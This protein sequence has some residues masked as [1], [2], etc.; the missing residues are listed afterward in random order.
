MKK[1]V[2]LG[3]AALC[4]TTAALAGVG[5]KGKKKSCCKKET[6]SCCKKTSASCCKDKGTTAKL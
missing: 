1:L 5:G 3:A 4:I 2:I 6:T